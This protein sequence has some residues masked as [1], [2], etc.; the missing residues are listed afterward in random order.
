MAELPR[1]PANVPTVR[2]DRENPY[3]RLQAVSVFVGDLDRSIDFFVSSGVIWYL[4]R[5]PRQ[6]ELMG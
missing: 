1:D 2:L 4:T 3:L 5:E 6:A